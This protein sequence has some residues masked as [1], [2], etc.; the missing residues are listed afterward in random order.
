M[1][2]P[3]SILLLFLA[4]FALYGKAAGHDFLVNWDD[5]LYVTANP[6]IIGFS[7]EHL[8]NAFTRYYAHNYAP[9]QIISYMLDYTLWGLDPGAFKLTNIF[10]HCLNASLYYILM[11]RITGRRLAALAAAAI[12]LC[13]PVQVESVVWISQRKNLLAMSF[14]LLSFL[15]YLNWKERR[16][17]VWYVLSLAAFLLALF[18]KSVVSILPLVLLVYDL[19]FC[20]CETVW[21][22][23]RD[24][25]PYALLALV[26]AVLAVL[27]HDNGGG[28]TGFLWGVHL[29]TLYNM[30]PVFSRYLLLLLVPAQLSIIYNGPVR[31][32]LDTEIVLSLMLMVILIGGCGYLYRRNRNLCFW[33]SLFLIGL[34]P[35]SNIIPMMTLM[36][37]RYLYF[38]LLGFAALITHLPVFEHAANRVCRPVVVNIIGICAVVALSSISWQ[39]IDVWRNSVTLWSDAVD[40]AP[41]GTWYGPYRDYIAETLAESLCVTGYKRQLAGDIP[42]ARSYYLRALSYDPFTPQALLNLGSLATQQGRPLLGR[43]FL[44]RMTETYLHDEQGYQALG[45]NY[46]LT[47]ELDAA[48]VNFRKVI[49]INPSNG[50]ADYFIR[51]I[52]A[53][54]EKS[55]PHPPAGR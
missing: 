29:L 46:F 50:I 30:A 34:L 54:R 23:V 28:A 25:V 12:F 3:V 35:V 16:S 8:R 53:Q 38:P 36:N 41:D 2:H 32:A 49:G 15:S 43:P 33:G 18:S 55:A 22:L 48:E 9:L 27:S 39:R 45:Q 52:A 19:C 20:E 42:E 40:T 13:H 4:G 11:V 26:G 10:F 24:K 5:N 31:G 6:D 14:F 7:M 37:D 17:L 21:R 47:G 51:T 1:S 44:T